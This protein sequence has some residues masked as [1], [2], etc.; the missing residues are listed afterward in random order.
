M[1]TQRRGIPTTLR[2]QLPRDTA[3]ISVTSPSGNLTQSNLIVLNRVPPFTLSLNCTNMPSPQDFI[4]PATAAP[5]HQL[6]P[7]Q[8]PPRVHLL[9]PHTYEADG[10]LPRPREAIKIRLPLPL[11]GPGSAQGSSQNSSDYYTASTTRRRSNY[12]TAFVMDASLDLRG[13]VVN[14]KLW[15]TPSYSGAI[16]E[17]FPSSIAYVASLDQHHQDR[18]IPVPF[19]NQAGVPIPETPTA[20]GPPLVIGG[21]QDRRP[22][23]V[24]IELQSAALRFTTK[25]S[26]VPPKRDNQPI[27]DRESGNRSHRLYCFQ[28]MSPSD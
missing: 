22:S 26:V 28:S 6:T 15:P 4:A 27:A 13:R 5:A 14:L 3:T 17:G 1:L 23:W 20:F 21:Y 9:V 10:I 11:S 12:H 19:V 2:H 18:H 25:V 7:G 16:F 8:T 24:L